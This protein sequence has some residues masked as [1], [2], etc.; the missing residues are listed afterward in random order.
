MDVQSRKTKLDRAVKRR[1]SCQKMSRW[2]VFCHWS[3]TCIV[4]RNF[5]DRQ[6]F[7][8]NTWTSA[9]T[10]YS[11]TLILGKLNTAHLGNEWSWRRDLRSTILPN[12]DSSTPTILLT[13]NRPNMSRVISRGSRLRCWCLQ[14]WDSQR[15]PAVRPNALSCKVAHTHSSSYQGILI[16]KIFQ[17]FLYHGFERTTQNGIR[18]FG[19]IKVSMTDNY[20]QYANLTIFEACNVGSN[21]SSRMEVSK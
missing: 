11:W 18:I 2:A 14:S 12:P 4:I 6:E 15:N 17:C 5:W 13:R 7:E 1:E 8:R 19:Q 16:S 9:T 10:L 3:W 20:M 21:H